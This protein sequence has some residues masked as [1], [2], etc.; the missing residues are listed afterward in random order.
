M[1]KTRNLILLLLLCCLAMTAAAQVYNLAESETDEDAINIISYFDKGDTMTYNY[2]H[3]KI[4]IREGDTTRESSFSLEFRI[5]V[6]DSTSQGYRME[7]TPLSYEFTE[8]DSTSSAITRL[9]WSILKDVR[10]IFS[11]NEVGEIQHIEN[12]REISKQLKAILKQSIDKAFNDTPELDSVMS[13]KQLERM[14]SIKYSSEEGIRDAY[15]ELDMLFAY[16]GIAFTP[17]IKEVDAFVALSGLDEE[18]IIMSLYAKNNSGAKTITKINR[19]SYIDMARML[20]LDALVMP[21]LL[22]TGTILSYVRS[23]E[24]ASSESRIES[25]YHIVGNKVEAIEFNIKENIPHL[26]G[27]PL[28]DVR[29]KKNILICAIIR[30]RQVIIPNG[31]DTIELDDSVIIVTKDQRFSELRD[32]LE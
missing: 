12:W 24:N 6:I 26:T 13:R 32:I 14:L 23:L 25:L 10:C 11:T 3:E 29:I 28:K 15:E 4:K 17:G 9:G 8:E 7:V 22:T 2:S 1:R 27:I 18:N 30:K 19:D 21:K 16:H 31:S 5:A 20:G